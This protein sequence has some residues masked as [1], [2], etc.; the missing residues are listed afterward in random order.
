MI[1]ENVQMKKTIGP[2]L[3]D[4]FSRRD[5]TWD[6]IQWIITKSKKVHVQKV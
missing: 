2:S 1:K 4:P 3:H 5:E 6:V